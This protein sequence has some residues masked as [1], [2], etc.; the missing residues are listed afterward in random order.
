MSKGTVF[1]CLIVLLL[2]GC[3]AAQVEP[4]LSPVETPTAAIPAAP[5]R[6]VEAPSAAGEPVS[7]PVERAIQ[8]LAERLGISR[9]EVEV[10]SV[11]EA[12]WPIQDALCG[13]AAETGADLPAFVVG[14]E[15]I[16]SAGSKLY[17]Y[18]AWRNRV[19]LCEP[20]AAAEKWPAKA[21]AAVRAAV[22]DWAA[23]LGISP[24]QVSVVAVKEVDW[25]DASLGCPEPGMVYAMV[26]TPGYVIQLRADGQATTYHASVQG[27]VVECNR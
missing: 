8:D 5:E 13:A 27:R 26:I 7:S 25:P 10:V 2:A 15:I 12:E 11:T 20:L 18:Q 6:A 21:N 4:S 23:K 24:E 14:R 16:L 9:D 3:A 1:A 19:A 17:T 22:N